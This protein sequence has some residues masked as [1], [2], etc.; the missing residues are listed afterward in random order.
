MNEILWRVEWWHGYGWPQCSYR[1][2]K[3][4]V[5][6]DRDAYERTLAEIAGLASHHTLVS[7]SSA[8][9]AW[10]DENEPIPLEAVQ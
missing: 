7:V 5:F 3:V 9:V 10:R 6:R 4:R 2:R 1:V 8:V